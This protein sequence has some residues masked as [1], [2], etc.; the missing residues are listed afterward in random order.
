MTGNLWGAD[1]A[2][3]RTL[4]QQF[5]KAS[6]S[7]QQQSSL[8]T[9]QINNNTSWKGN[10]ALQFR[11]NWNGNHH[12]LLQRAADRLKEE[13]KKLLENANDQEKASGGEPGSGGG[14]LGGRSGSG[15]QGADNDPWGPDWLAKGSPFRDAWSFRGAIKASVDL[16]K[17][18]FGL[19]TMASKGLDAFQ[20]A[21]KWA[22]LPGKSIPYNLMD[23]ATDWMG[24]KNLYKYIPALSQFGGVFKESTFL[25]KG[26][27]ELLEG[28][29]KGGLGRVVGWAGVGVNAFDTAKYAAE[30][31]TGDAIWSGAKTAL[32]V[33]CFLPPPAG[34]V[35]QVVS[36][37]IAI[38]E[39]PAVK[40]FVND[41]A[42]AVANTVTDAVKDPGKFVEDTGKN[43]ADLGKGAAS[44]LGFG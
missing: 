12:A 33:A 38:Y 13:S 28:L 4:A 16:P 2:Q 34:T 14:P 31:K 19:A 7:L 41:A 37:G 44:F 42:G 39:I 36:A 21:E 8:L 35:C 10:D 17:N 43:L 25:F 27:G 11:S 32:G 40:S 9:S 5:G 30:G 18:V 29:G 3:L 1:V 6:E 15:S 26:Q 23:T 22:K 20:D 24:L